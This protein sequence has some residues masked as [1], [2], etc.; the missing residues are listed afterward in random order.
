MVIMRMKKANE[1]EIKNYLCNIPKFK[2]ISGKSLVELTTYNDI[3]LWWFVNFDFK[4]YL[5]GFSCA[6]DDIAKSTYKVEIINIVKQNSFF[7]FSNYLYRSIL[8]KLCEINVRL[9]DINNT[10]KKTQILVVGQ[11]VEWRT[12][13][14]ISDQSSKKADAFFDSTITMLKKDPDY[15]IITTYPVGNPISGLKIIV[16]KRKSQKDIVHKPFDMYISFDT[17]KKSQKAKMYF[18]ELW[19]TILYNDNFNAL[20]EY[21]EMN[22]FP[23]RDKISNYFLGSFCSTVQQIEM[24]KKMIET[25]NPDL[26][27]LVNEYG[28]FELS[29]VVA[30]KIKNIPVLTVQHGIITPTH[31]GYIHS[32]DELS[33]NG[34]I[35]SPYYPIPDKTAVFGTYHKDLLTKVSAYPENSVVVTGQPRYDILYHAN[36]IYNKEQF[37]KKY[38]INKNH[39]IVLWTTQCHGLSDDENNANFKAMFGTLQNLQDVTLILKQHPGEGKKYTKMIEDALKYCHLNIVIPPKDSDTYEQLYVCDLMI[40]RHS[41]TAMEAVALNKPVIVL[42]LSGKPDIINYV[43]EGVA[44]GVYRENNLK[45]AIEKLLDDDSE[46][47]E[48]R[49]SYIEKYLYK[50]D[51]KSTERVVQLIKKMLD[52]KKGKA[53]SGRHENQ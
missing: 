16:D 7:R 28:P 35:K 40:T 11:N 36:E 24:A 18:S 1:D 41:T 2:I 34:S 6:S 26:I 51:G 43:E 13:K 32:K 48:N 19:K 25:E 38:N 50:I 23:L 30:G 27:L 46:L 3:A 52:E 53:G 37:L 22:F 42:N 9:Y 8:S 14:D 29:L 39:K 17:W 20:F 47:A 15:E 31:D 21:S 4:S 45:I 10:Q 33:T 44:L 49:R 12:I 5:N